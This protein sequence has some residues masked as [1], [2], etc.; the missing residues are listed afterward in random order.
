[1]LRERSDV[2]GVVAFDPEVNVAAVGLYRSRG[3]KAWIPTDCLP[4]VVMERSRLTEALTTDHHF[5]QAGMK[6]LM[7]SLPSL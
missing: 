5:E 6:A 3:D 7:L 1:M 4:F 2:C